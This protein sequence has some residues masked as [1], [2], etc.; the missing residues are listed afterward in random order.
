[1][2]KILIYLCLLLPVVAFSQGMVL[3]SGDQLPDISI[4]Q[5]VNAP[6]KSFNIKSSKDKKFYILNFW[7]TWCSP[8]IPEMDELSRLQKANADKLQVI[9]I[10]D[11]EPVKLQKYL[12]N[13]PTTLWLATDTSYLF[14]NLFNFA[15]VS[16]SAIV[17]AD[18]KIV[19]LMKTH[20][21]TQ[22]LLDSL[23]KGEKITSDADLKEKPVNA[24][25]DLFAVDSTLS[26]NFTLRSYMVGQQ[27][28]GKRYGGKSIY[29]K[30]RLSFFNTGITSLYKD[31]YNIVSSNQI[32]YEVDEK[33]IDNYADKS[34]LYCVDILV[35][36]EEKD[37]I[38]VMLQ[39][40]LNAVLPVKARIE[41]KTIPVYVVTNNGFSLLVS[42]KQTSY[43]FSGSGYDGTA[44][45]IS[46]FAND[47]LSNELSL[48]VVDETNLKGKYDIKTVV[49][50]R[51]QAEIFK[52]IS[53]LGLKIERQ[54]LKMP[55][56]VLYKATF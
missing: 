10:S 17:N 3:K 49:E 28:M 27:S 2:K 30:R 23:Y 53:N 20:S 44:V 32:I 8:C 18:K 29:A 19:A 48:P 9:A 55:M 37:S 39:Q 40:K 42:D 26:A 41:Y 43:G 51:T 11:D 14:Y 5:I 4:N 25:A 6:V 46:D 56:L 38:Y 36:P 12:K 22:G 1:M 24:S 47:Y 34:T 15:S 50:M 35:K 33:K 45:T 54:E 16:H 13:K 7:G 31:A 21:I 52:S